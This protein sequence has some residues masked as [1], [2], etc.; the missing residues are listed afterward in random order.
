MPNWQSWLL[1][2]QES[3]KPVVKLSVVKNCYHGESSPQKSANI[4]NLKIFFR[5]LV[6]LHISGNIQGIGRATRQKA[7]GSLHNHSTRSGF[8]MPKPLHG[9]EINSKTCKPLL[10]CIC[11][12]WRTYYIMEMTMMP[13]IIHLKSTVVFRGSLPI[14][15]KLLCVFYT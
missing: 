15:T 12:R 4:T 5:E 14:L 7:F 1:N 2:Y 13:S 3:C 8:L 11:Y 9:W 10:F 6:F